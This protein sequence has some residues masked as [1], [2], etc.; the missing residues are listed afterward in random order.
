MI[1]VDDITPAWVEAYLI[2]MVQTNAATPDRERRWLRG[3]ISGHPATG[4]DWETHLAHAD[5][6]VDPVTGKPDTSLPPMRPAYPTSAQISR[7]ELVSGWI[8]R[9]VAVIE[10]RRILGCTLVIKAQGHTTIWPRVRRLLERAPV[11]R[12]SDSTLRRQ[13]NRALA[14]IASG[15]RADMAIAAAEKASKAASRGSL[16]SRGQIGGKATQR[17]AERKREGA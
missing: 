16:V 17:A 9:Y 14:D 4:A 8:G 12:H 5:R 2:E 11:R 10:N 3:L 7:A 6:P 15:I 13:Y 1:T